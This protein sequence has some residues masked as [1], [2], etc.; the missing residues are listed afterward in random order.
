MR[1]PTNYHP[2]TASDFV[3]LIVLIFGALGV[4]WCI[5][6]YLL[7]HQPI[8]NTSSVVQTGS[9]VANE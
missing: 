8:K 9:E 7:R 2:L 5:G 4:A 1:R 3:I 6:S